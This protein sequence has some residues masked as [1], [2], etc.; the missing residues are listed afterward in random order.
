MSTA[1]GLIPHDTATEKRSVCVQLGPNHTAVYLVNRRQNWD[2][3]VA[4][5][6][7]IMQIQQK[8]V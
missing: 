6:S 1:V 5:L 2:P 7:D 8:T 4:K 3:T